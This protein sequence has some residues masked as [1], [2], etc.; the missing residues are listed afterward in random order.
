MGSRSRKRKQAARKVEQ[1]VADM[2]SSRTPITVAV[3]A[4]SDARA[5]MYANKQR[6][7]SPKPSHVL[8]KE[9]SGHSYIKGDRAMPPM[10]TPEEAREN[11]K[12]R[13]SRTT[14]VRS[15]GGH[16]TPSDTGERLVSGVRVEADKDLSTVKAR[17]GREYV[18]AVQDV[19]RWKNNP[20]HGVGGRKL[21][22]PRPAHEYKDGY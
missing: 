7:T 3:N 6:K 19:A 11:R 20:S 12:I 18:K 1:V 9:A 13:K 2:A 21:Y 8:A 4:L 5:A 22:P 10:L 15:Q 17:V 16:Y 14:K